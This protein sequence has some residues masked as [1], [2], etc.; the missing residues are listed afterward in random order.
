MT[1][2]VLLCA[3]LVCPV[4][5]FAQAVAPAG[6]AV[7]QLRYFANLNIADSV[8][9]LTN[10]GALGGSDPGGR[11]CANVFVFDPASDMVACCAC[12]VAPNGLMSYS[13]KDDLLSNTLSP[14]VPTSVTVKLLAT[15]GSQFGVALTC[16]PKSPAGTN[17]ARGMVAWAGTVRS[18]RLTSPPVTLFTATETEFSKGELSA[19][20]LNKL[21]TSCGFIQANGSG[22][23][24]CKACKT[25]GK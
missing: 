17:L 20:E 22:F 1:L 23:G 9:N 24:I 18:T 8:I 11:I 25:G 6:D 10:T 7:Y 19:T 5:I 3:A 2:R 16:N 15:V 12:P 21:T 14:A 13:V 4:Q